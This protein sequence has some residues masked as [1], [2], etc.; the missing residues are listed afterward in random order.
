MARRKQT[1]RAAGRLEGPGLTP[2]EAAAD[3]TLEYSISLNYLAA[4]FASA[5]RSVFGVA[6]KYGY[7]AA[8][9]SSIGDGSQMSA[10]LRI[11]VKDIF[12][13]IE[14]LDGIGDLTAENIQ[15][16]D[17]TGELIRQALIQRRELART[18]RRT[19]GPVTARS[20]AEREQLV[21]AS[22]NAGDQAWF[23]QWN[24]RDRSAWA[25]VQ[26]NIRGP[27]AVQRI[28]PPLY[29]NALI[30]LANFFL[31]ALYYAIYLLPF[32]LLF[33][34]VWSLRNKISALFR[35]AGWN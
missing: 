11:R 30:G 13:A 5:R 23:E 20:W 6:R 35:G 16:T 9:E 2:F 12:A 33:L 18:Q 4:D 22:E 7:V 26:V 17:H 29:R 14:E 15:T 28:Q 21:S 31:W 27:E 34:L 24:I 25:T 8:S 32:A 1:N 10:T 19:Q 3:R